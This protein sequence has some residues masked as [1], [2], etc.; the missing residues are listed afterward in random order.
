MTKVEKNKIFD[1]AMRYDFAAGIEHTDKLYQDWY[2]T[3]GHFDAMF[4]LME[5]LGIEDEYSNYVDEHKKQLEEWK[6][7]K[8][9]I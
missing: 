5:N 6:S 1:L 4:T 7:G 2:R 8:F 3:I 9:Y